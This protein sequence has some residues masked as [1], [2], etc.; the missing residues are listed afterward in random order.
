MKK[1]TFF[2]DILNNFIRYLYSF[3]VFEK[4]GYDDFE[5]PKISYIVGQFQL[6]KGMLIIPQSSFCFTYT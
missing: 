6:V 5:Q 1:K 2:L 4:E 3:L